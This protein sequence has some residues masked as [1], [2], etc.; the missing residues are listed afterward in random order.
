[1]CPCRRRVLPEVWESWSR[2]SNPTNQCLYKSD[3]RKW[4]PAEPAPRWWL[5]RQAQPPACR[6]TFATSISFASCRR[7]LSVPAGD[8]PD[9]QLRNNVDHQGNEKQ[10]QPNLHQGALVKVFCRLTEFVGNHAGQTV[11]GGKE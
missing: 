1:R 7:P 3:N 5:R 6:L 2:S 4:P 11:A 10:G 9:H 8:A